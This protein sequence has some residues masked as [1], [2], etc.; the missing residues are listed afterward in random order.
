MMLPLLLGTLG[1]VVVRCGGPGRSTEVF[2]DMLLL[3]AIGE[4]TGPMAPIGGGDM[5]IEGPPTGIRFEVAETDPPPPGSCTL[6]DVFRLPATA[7]NGC[8]GEVG[9]WP[10]LA[11]VGLGG[12]TTLLPVVV[13]MRPGW[14]EGVYGLPDWPGVEFVENP[15]FTE[16]DWPLVDDCVNPPLAWAVGNP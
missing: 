13:G 1:Y 7:G 9:S 16:A 10:A 14:L 8:D 11:G 3:A 12:I 5:P 6:P 2:S 15:P 4:P